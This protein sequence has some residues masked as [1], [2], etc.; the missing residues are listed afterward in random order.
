MVIYLDPKFYAAI[1]VLFVA[2]Q[3]RPSGATRPQWFAALNLAVVGWIFGGAVLVALLVLSA[4]LWL[5]LKGQRRIAAVSEPGALAATGA[6]FGAALLLFVT[7][8]AILDR[9][10]WPLSAAAVE[11]GPLAGLASAFQLLAFSYVV[12]RV[13]DA[14]R[15]VTAGAP[16]LDPLALSGYLLPFFMTP[17]GPVNVYE[18][19]V[20][21]AATPQPPPLVERAVASADVLTTGLVLKYVLAELVRVY[22]L[23][24]KGAWPTATLLDTACAFFYVF[25]DFAGYSLIALGVGRLL[26]VPTPVNF[27]SPFRSTSL[28]EFWTRWHVS[29]GD[30][31][32]RTIFLPVQ[33]ALVRRAGRRYAHV[34]NLAALVLSFGAVGVWHRFSLTF[35]AW[36]VAIGVLMAAEK[37]AAEPLSRLVRRLPWCAALWRVLGPIYVVSLVVVTL[38]IVMPELLGQAK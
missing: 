37:L 4:G 36:G 18:Q 8:K 9:V 12:L 19:H 28:T 6:I 20:A 27:K 16:L 24:A 25:L 29:L 2:L 38:H 30:F 17:A 23:G 31:V 7:H 11:A 1:A 15:A 10:G 35:L 21:M 14:T 26:D 32:R 34:C 3:L 13:A 5:A 33:V 22:L